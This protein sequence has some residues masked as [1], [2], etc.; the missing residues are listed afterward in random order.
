MPEDVKAEEVVQEAPVVE[1]PAPVEAPPQQQMQRQNDTN[2]REVRA[3]MAAQ[4]EEIDR[5][6]AE[7]E[8]ERDAA[9]FKD[10]APDDYMTVAKT[11]RMIEK[12]AE[13]KAQEIASKIVEESMRKQENNMA[14]QRMRDKVS[15]YDY[16]IENYAVPM[17]ES[18]KGMAEALRASDNPFQLAYNLAKASDKYIH[19]NSK[20]PTSAKAEKILK[21]TERPISAAASGTSMKTEADKFANLSP[22]DYWR[23]SQEYANR[24]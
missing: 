3:M 11:Q 19:D 22:A 1:T 21:N 2:W 9:E 8:A 12:R 6:K 5:L 10:L 4:K 24:A 13:K 16:I 14:E 15:D 20:Q 17:L 18:N 7:K 23:L